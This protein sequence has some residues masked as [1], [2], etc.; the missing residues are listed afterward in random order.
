MNNGATL[1]RFKGFYDDLFA[2]I[3]NYGQ[4][5][6][7]GELLAYHFYH[8][9][10]EGIECKKLKN[11]G[12]LKQVVT[13]M[14]KG[15]HYNGLMIGLFGQLSMYFEPL[16]RGAYFGEAVSQDELLIQLG[17]CGVYQ[18]QLRK[19]V[20]ILLNQWLIN[21]TVAVNSPQYDGAERYILSDLVLELPEHLH[22]TKNCYAWFCYELS[23]LLSTLIQQK[24]VNV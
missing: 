5:C 22:L 6:K 10:E 8:T 23:N 21:L 3:G 16:V 11:H 1:R 12:Q 20:K 18:D 9:V 17:E 7:T 15:N 13:R 4:D 14:P 24:A 19:Y 2:S